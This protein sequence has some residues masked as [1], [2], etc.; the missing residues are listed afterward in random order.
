VTRLAVAV[1]PIAASASSEAHAP[2]LAQVARSAASRWLTA[3]FITLL[4]YALLGKAWAYL[5][6]PPVF[7]GELVLAAGVA[8]ALAGPPRWKRIIDITPALWL[9]AL[10]AWGLGR[11]LPFV[12]VYGVDALR[13]AMLWGYSAYAFVLF[14]LLAAD[15]TLFGQLVR[16]YRRFV[17]IFLVGIG[18]LGV[19]ARAMP[20]LDVRYPWV[21]L[22]ITDIKGGDVLV[23]LGGVL[24]FWFAGFG[25]A[26]AWGWLLLLMLDVALFGML[27]RAGFIAF[28]GAFAACFA[29]RPRSRAGGR[30]IGVAAV[31]LLALAVSGLRIEIA[32]ST[33]G[34]VRE[35]SFNQVLSTFTSLTGDVGEVSMDSTKEWR[36]DWWK[37]IVRYTLHG[38]YFWTGKGFG[39]N[40]ADDDGFQVLEDHSLRTP[41]CVHMTFLARA[42]VPGLVLWA[43]AQGGW[44]LAILCEQRR[45]RRRGDAHWAGLFVFLL[46]YWLALLINGSFDVFIEGPVGGIWFWSIYGVGLAALWVHRRMPDAWVPEPVPA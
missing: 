2:A 23:H 18:I 43:L 10:C 7:I 37:E 12:S 15:P 34:K 9:I 39:V 41:H 6:V 45:A 14:A 26:G 20:G 17:P 46:G 42:G 3:L 44:A 29:L 25:Q 8:V 28:L 22:S 36:L 24:A 1:R 19:V 16:A 35:I 32:S 31:G 5:G 27:D 21:D 11:T 38:D 33:V 40:L 4:G 13:D 30:F